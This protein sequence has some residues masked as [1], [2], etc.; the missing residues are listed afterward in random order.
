MPKVDLQKAASLTEEVIRDYH[1]IIARDRTM[2]LDGVA[3]MQERM[4]L[5]GISYGDRVLCPFLRPFF[6]SRAEYGY[7]RDVVKS[8]K[9]A[10]D[11]VVNRALADARWLDWLGLSDL[12]KQFFR[13]EPGFKAASATSR[14][15]SFLTPT[16]FKFVEYNAECPTGIGYGDV[17]AEIFSALPT[18]KEFRKHR[19]IAHVQ[20]LPALLATLVAAYRQWGGRN[21]PNIAIVDWEDV[22]TRT[23]FE[24]V[25]EF[26]DRRG[27]RTII[28]DPRHLEL[29]NKKLYRGDFRIDLVY[30]RV[31]VDEFLEK[32][33]ECIPMAEA[34][35]S[36]RVCVVNSFR[37]KVLHKK[38]IFAAL[39]EDE[40]L[41]AMKP[42]TR[43]AV[44]EHI[45]WTRKVADQRVKLNGRQIELLA[46]IE[47][48]RRK[49]VLKPNDDYG[50][51]GVVI[52]WETEQDAWNQH[53]RKAM[54]GGYIVQQRVDVRKEPFPDIRENLRLKEMIVDMDPFIFSGRGVVG[55]L[56]RLSAG[57]LC[58]VTSGGGQVP[59]FVV[60]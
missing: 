40:F 45:P 56:T 15:D 53:I 18:F 24:I 29:R 52:G 57:S 46:Y 23:E 34:Y 39:H 60:G 31:L 8:L 47:G 32:L 50:G 6:L 30:R 9:P 49:L 5:R 11:L 22:P 27:Y 25:A 51:R 36:G 1:A 3:E 35:R 28:C 33:G 54:D 43:Q 44:L 48:N 41:D 10:F 38:A 42:E 19:K 20:A 58:N 4:R 14:L 59:T 21:K 7:V 13:Y 12:E 26:F 2:A 17:L 16:S 37:T 55:C